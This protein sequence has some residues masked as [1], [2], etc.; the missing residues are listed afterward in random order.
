VEN[1]RSNHCAISH[2]LQDADI[3]L[4]QEHW[5]LNFEKE[6]AT[7]NLPAWSSIV[8]SI[9]DDLHE[10]DVSFS[11]RPQGHGGTAVLYKHN[12]EAYITPIQ[13]GNPRILPVL[14]QLPGLQLC[15]INCYLPSGNSG[16]A[17]Q[18][19]AEDIGIIQAIVEKFQSSWRIIIAGDLNA[20]IIHR[21]GKK[22]KLLL[23]LIEQL[24]LNLS[25]CTNNSDHTFRHKSY[26]NVTSY[27][28]YF[29]TSKDIV[30]KLLVLN[31]SPVNTSAHYP[32]LLQVDTPQES[33]STEM[34]KKEIVYSKRTVKW[35]DGDPELYEQVIESALVESNLNVL[36]AEEAITELERII[37]YAESQAFPVKASRPV[38][39]RRGPFSPL[40]ADAVATSKFAH[41]SWKEAGRPPAEHPLTLEKKL[42]SK[43]VRTA[44]RQYEAEKR[45]KLYDQILNAHERDQATFFKLLKRRH[46][47]A[48]SDVALRIDGDLE[49][50][51]EAQR[52]AWA[53]FYEDLATSTSDGQ[54]SCTL[55]SIRILAR[56][57][58]TLKVLRD[59]TEKAIRRLNSGK[60]AD[61]TELQAEHFKLG[62]RALVDAVTAI[63]NLMLQER[64]IPDTM[65]QGYKIPIPKKGKDV[66]ERGNHRGITITPVLGKILEHILEDISRPG[67]GGSNSYLQFGFTEGKSP[68]MATLCLTEA[69]AQ[70]K[71]EAQP[72]YVATLDAQKAFDVVDHDLLKLKL[73]HTGVRGPQWLIIDNLYSNCSETVRWRG[74]YSRPYKVTQGVRQGGV[75]STSLY[76]EYV[77]PLLT[78]F[79]RSGVGLHIG[80]IYLGSP[81]CADD[82]LLLSHSETELQA[83]LNVAYTYSAHNKYTLH[84][85]KS[86]VTQLVGTNKHP[87]EL[88]L[89]DKSIT[90]S[91]QFTH[92]GLTWTHGRLSPM[93]EERI[94]AGRRAAYMLV[95]A[96]I[97]GTDGL[98]P[99]VSARVMTTQVLPRM[100]HGLEAVV[101]KTA[102]LLQ[103]S[104]IHR[105]LLRQ[106]QTLPE[107]VACVAIHLLTGTYPLEAHIQ[108]K[109]LMLFGALC[110]MPEGS[111]LREMV[112]R[113]LSRPENSHSWFVHVRKLAAKHDIDLMSLWRNPTAAVT[114][115][116]YVKERVYGDSYLA[117]VQEAT[118]R[119]SLKWLD[120]RLCR[121]G[122][123]HPVWQESIYNL[124]ET[125]RAALR[126]KLLTGVYTLQDTLEKFGK[127]P[128]S[129]CTICKSGDNEDLLHFLLK[130]EGLAATRNPIMM[131]IDRLLQAINVN[132]NDSNIKTKIILNGGLGG[133]GTTEEWRRDISIK[134]N[135]LIDGLH[136]S[137]E[138][139]LQEK[140]VL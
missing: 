80:G 85:G 95:G 25:R 75:L 77:N 124:E 71:D 29:I 32:V 105:G 92:L 138:T 90:T 26:T 69:A 5:L 100:I 21:S 126:A 119:S 83:M 87:P 3:I 33:A 36:M 130:C 84:P 57:M 31:D 131:D 24:N 11:S 134:V 35:L 20:D 128:N 111:P 102:E 64:Q 65:K 2:L 38:R 79:E 62:G 50:N 103:L 7:S 86:T 123:P 82:V 47:S 98:N 73:H 94:S 34:K 39:G 137:R 129:I 127:A 54:D 13:D 78:D 4:L 60:A 107:R 51:S 16:T 58:P 15:I 23:N 66:L 67:L 72:L 88:K 133:I 27:L 118:T 22:E 6:E 81:T 8:R 30:S 125:R 14:L 104:R 74:S 40:I 1:I 101:P 139:A 108:H 109:S 9:D 113:Q 46:G 70:A 117:M 63:I 96:G 114:W 122:K 43:A 45:R 115:K 48:A 97:H 106:H 68:S 116:A 110:R 28:D 59:H 61:L 99:V 52:E 12:M 41:F 49:Y 10:D 42:A 121:R 136:K 89:G 56:Q 120:L 55:E 132:T 112:Q 140:V 91:S 135:A 17:L 19:F 93:L 53:S 37:H 18:R 44:Q 76:K